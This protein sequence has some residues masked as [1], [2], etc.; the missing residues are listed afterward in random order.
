MATYYKIE[1]LIEKTTEKAVMINVDVELCNLEKVVKKAIWLPK[2][3][4]KNGAAPE[5]I[6]TKKGAELMNSFSMGSGA[7][8][9]TEL[10]EV[11]IN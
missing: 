1:A 5:W 11:V 8:I 10:E 3:V 7:V 9:R 4:L 6:M 2:S